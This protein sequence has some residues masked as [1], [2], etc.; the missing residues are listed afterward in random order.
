MTGVVGVDLSLTATGLARADGTT[1]VIRPKTRGLVRVAQISAVVLDTVDHGD[2]VVIE[3]YS[4]NSRGSSIVDLAELG[5]VVRYLLNA[6][7]DS[8]LDIPPATLKR[9]STG[10]GNADKAMVLKAAWQRLGYDGTDHNEADALWL[11]AI[12]LDLTD[13]SEVTMPVVNRAALDSLR[14]AV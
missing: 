10:R 14:V 5:G 2:L 13:S 3:G 9:Y 1:C 11:R 8:Y 7:H 12:G 4:Y 6:G